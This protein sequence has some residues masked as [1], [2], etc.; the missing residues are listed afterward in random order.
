MVEVDAN[1]SVSFALNGG[2]ALLTVLA[3][4]II[5]S[6]WVVA[7]ITPSVLAVLLSLSAGLTLFISLSVLFV[8]C[9]QVLM[10]AIETAVG[11][12]EAAKGHAWL[13]AT[14]CF[15]SGIVLIY[16]I[17]AGVHCLL[18]VD[19]RN[20][21]TEVASVDSIDTACSDAP[22]PR[23]SSLD[24]LGLPDMSGFDAF[25]TSRAP[26]EK[27]QLHRSSL[28]H[29]LTLCGN[30][31]PKGVAT[32]VAASQSTALG[33]A[34]AIG[35]GLYNVTQGFT[36][37]STVYFN[38][39]SR[40][41]AVLSTLLA[42]FAEHLGGILAWLILGHSDEVAQGVL[43][44]V[45]SGIMVCTSMKKIIPT[46]CVF[47]TNKRLHIVSAGTLAGSWLMASTLIFFK[48]IGV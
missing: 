13:A 31:S 9:F 3:S 28:V 8:R 36:T 15:G 19:R 29:L 42:A 38:T 17:D 27:L 5:F 45:M 10:S 18:T 44:G 1:V 7:R 20:T 48:F 33:L 39:G 32:F 2:T 24:I 37:S 40:C 16:I 12:Q 14:L 46:A 21:R 25:A 11:D 6:D 34:I 47:A 4:A 43:F 22:P 41:K 23:E 35:I 26:T 30:N